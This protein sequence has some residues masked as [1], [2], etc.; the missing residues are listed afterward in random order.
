MGHFFSLKDFWKQKTDCNAFTPTE[1]KYYTFMEESG[2]PIPKDMNRLVSYRPIHCFEMS[3][4]FISN[5]WTFVVS[6]FTKK[7]VDKDNR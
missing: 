1:N 3:V 2:V 5:S 6:L 4:L 7:Q